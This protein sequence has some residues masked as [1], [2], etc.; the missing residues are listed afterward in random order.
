MWHI[1]TGNGWKVGTRNPDKLGSHQVRHLAS[2]IP[3]SFLS[4]L[5]DPAEGHFFAASC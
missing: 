1:L 4:Q 5:D 3:P 2:Q